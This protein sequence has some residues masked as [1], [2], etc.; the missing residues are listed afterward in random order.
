[1]AEA[2]DVITDVARHATVYAQALWRR[3]LAPSDTAK[4]VTLGDVVQHLDLLIKAVFNTHYSLRVAQPPSP[5][6]LLKK[7]LLRNEKPCGQS[8]IPA[9]DGVSLWLPA[10]LGSGESPLTLERYRT[11]ALQQAM[12][13][14]RGSANA[15][16]ALDNPMQ[17]SVYRLLEAWAADADLIR[18]L[19]GLAPSIRG[20]RQHALATRPPLHAFSKQ[21]QPLENFLRLLLSS[22][23]GA[24]LEGL[25]IPT[26]TADSLQLSE[27]LA[28][29]LQCAEAS[30]GLGAHLLF[31]DAWTGDL[32][33]P[34][35]G[36]KVSPLPGE[37]DNEDA[38]PRS[39]RLTRQPTARKACADEDDEREQGMWMV[40]TA[41][42]L[43]KAEDPMGMQRPTDR[44][45][46]TPAADF[47]ESLSELN[48]AR[49]VVTA[50]RPK[51]VLLSDDPPQ[52]RV[53]RAAQDILR[54]AI[55]YPEWDYR[56]QIYHDPGTSLQLCPA[57][58]G[59]QQWVE[60]TLETHRPVLDAI[61][62]QFECL[63]AQR[64][65][66]RKQ[67]EGDDIDLEAYIDG[68]AEAR[69]G[70][71]MPQA[72]YQTQRR[73]RRDMAIML[74]IDV[75]GSTDSWLS[76]HRRV[77]DVEREALLLVCLALESLGEPYSVL[78]FSG[79]GPQRVTIRTLKA[80][81][82]RYSDE[83]G[84][85]IAALEP[86]RYTR[87]GAA[88]R[89][90]STLLM[91]EAAT[92]RLLLLL[93]DGKPNDV[94]Q[95]EGRYGV[96][97]MRQAVTE[98]KLQG[99]YPFCLTIDRQAANYLPAVFGS[100]QYALLHRPELLPSVLLDWIRRLV[101]A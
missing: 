68:C 82:E 66:L 4:I 74:L 18:L 89:H 77:I 99:I 84:R 53:Q 29:R 54:N 85:R 44:D 94:D 32:R 8:A 83:V 47:A 51:E 96:E 9:T 57:Q 14:R 7:L 25:A 55:S 63:R 65:R 81:D 76:N 70:L 90:A 62:R 97:D 67:W 34:P 42:P 72:L 86:E 17:R 78:A 98:A 26:E 69:A 61:R 30:H 95:Y 3:H 20:L 100:R 93:S 73:G 23:V 31:L 10:H 56:R 27:T 12:R 49:L 28:Q 88:L 24:P 91:R 22:E 41:E 1:M 15:L 37:I 43:E 75:S 71:S 16:S 87:A 59:P 45:T 79:E 33:E 19:P 101:S 80:F 92:H 35:A 64:V 6:T 48:E 5:P 11:L 2:E 52:T 60:R 39:A 21:R 46:D 40:Q 13:A 38:L 58:D 50:G 36:Q